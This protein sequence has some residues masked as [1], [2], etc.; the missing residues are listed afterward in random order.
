MTATPDP[1]PPPVG[2]PSRAA[3][4]GAGVAGLATAVGLCRLGWDVQVYERADRVQALGTAFGIW[5]D[6]QRVLRGL[7]LE[8]LLTDAVRP[9]RQGGLRD[10]E[11]RVLFALPPGRDDQSRDAGLVMVSRS[12]L[13]QGLARALPAETIVTRRQVTGLADLPAD[14]DLVVAAD[15][16]RSRV[17]TEVLGSRTAPHYSGVIAFRGI[18]DGDFTSTQDIIGGEIWGAGIVF[19]ITPLKPGRTNWYC[20]VRAPE[21]SP[22]ELGDLRRMLAVW[23]DPI[24]ELINRARVEDYLRHPIF[25]LQPALPT[26][27]SGHV[28]VIGDAAHA[29][30]PHLGMGANQA[31]L[32]ADGLVSA[33][34]EQRCVPEALQ[35][36]DRR[37]RRVGQLSALGS[38]TLG[39]L[40]HSTRWAP[41][42]D[43]VLAGV[44]TLSPYTRAAR[45]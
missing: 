13:L 8:D 12:D 21:D 1:P 36:Y 43:M 6:A 3:V 30:T 34:A 38:R 9:M 20:A 22:I 42:R 19:G 16:I 27:V 7:G 15:G 31:L 29:M 18:V 25:D 5:P 17:R 10:A 45:R 11:G 44:G 24:P 4:V 28:A 2:E 37:R 40:A 33:I 35:A 23:P 41:L 26:T 32:D 14:V 39:R